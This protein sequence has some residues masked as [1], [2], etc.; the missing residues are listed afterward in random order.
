[1]RPWFM[2]EGDVV[3]FPK[4]DDKVLKL[5]N[6]GQYP[7]FLAGV[8]DLQSRVK[9]GTLSDEMYKKLYTDLLHRFMRRESA[10]TPWFIVEYK[11]LDQA[12][13]EII[14]QVQA[15]DTNDK[16]N[17]EK[18]AKLLD[19]V[20]SIL[21]SSDTMGRLGNTLKNTLSNEYKENELVAIS[22]MI[23]NSQL[24]Y[25]DKIAFLK[26]LKA[27]KCIDADMLKTPGNYPIGDLFFNDPKNIGIFNSLLS[28]GA[29]AKQKGKG[30]H[31]LAIMSKRIT[32][33]GAGDVSVDGIATELKVETAVGGGRLGEPG[34]M[35]TTEQLKTIFKKY[36]NLIP[37][38]FDQQGNFQK[39]RLNVRVF[40]QI[41][42]QA[43]LNSQE[44]K[45]LGMDVFGSFWGQH[46]K[47]VIAEFSKTNADPDVVTKLYVRA[48]FDWYKDWMANTK[49]EA[50]VNLAVLSIANKQL[51]VI[52]SGDDIVNG[53]VKIQN[54][55][56]YIVTPQPREVFTQINLK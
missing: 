19:Q 11:T 56:P 49:G 21:K 20:Y 9:Q 30:E 24:K 12:K 5:P 50:F 27:D 1:M 23:N 53:T 55:N 10:E 32:V 6:V 36:K 44:K 39:P 28:Y 43:K 41:A 25:Q 34:A 46:A 37:M 35:P 54:Q 15:L 33:K 31:A 13:Q 42:N 51:A 45:Q 7:D 14:Q 26:N 40:T 3:P 52:S 17:A 47:P 4:K 16:D 38:L 2:N 8:E 29:G 22:E 18:N 48:N